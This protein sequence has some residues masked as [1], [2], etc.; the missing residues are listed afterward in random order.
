LH[1]AFLDEFRDIVSPLQRIPVKL[2]LLLLVLYIL[3]VVLTPLEFFWLF[4]FYAVLIVA[5][6]AVSRLPLKF[7]FA[8][9]KEISP[10]ILLVL[11]SVPFMYKEQRLLVFS[12]CLVRAVLSALGMVVVFSTTSFNQILSGLKELGLPGIFIKLLSF[13]YRYLFVLEDEFEKMQ[14]SMFARK[15]ATG[16]RWFEMKSFANMLGVL[17]IRA[18]ERSERIYLAM[19]ARGLDG[20]ENN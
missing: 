5:A 9:L 17:F 20:K 14:R 13:M 15:V 16:R 1:H 6:I 3:A 11:I 7:I 12:R 2:K 10:F 18:F 4:I 8:H 19:C